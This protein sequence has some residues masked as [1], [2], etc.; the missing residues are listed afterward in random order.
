MPFPAFWGVIFKNSEGYNG[1]GRT[2]CSLFFWINV[3]YYFL[4]PYSL[5]A[6]TGV[7]A[8]QTPG[9]RPCLENISFSHSDNIK[10]KVETDFISVASNL[11]PRLITRPWVRG[12]VASCMRLWVARNLKETFVYI[13]I[14][15]IDK[16]GIWAIVPL[17]H[18]ISY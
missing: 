12:W 10:R 1:M 2:L 4:V 17:D 9:I 3:I 6:Q 15:Y 8:S 13:Y 18:F 16:H 7:P 5:G 14:Y 11:V